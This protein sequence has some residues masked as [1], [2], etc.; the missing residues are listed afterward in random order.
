MSDLERDM[1]ALVDAG[2]M[3]SIL[4]HPSFHE[5]STNVSLADSAAATLGSESMREMSDRGLASNGSSSSNS[6]EDSDGSYLGSPDKALKMQDQF[7]DMD[8]STDDDWV[9][10]AGGDDHMQKIK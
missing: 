9:E 5:S 4:N 2:D 7:Q 8:M 10:E 1:P 3:P 6:D